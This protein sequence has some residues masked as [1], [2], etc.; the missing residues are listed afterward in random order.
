MLQGGVMLPEPEGPKPD[1]S[2]SATFVP[3]SAGA[4]IEE[5]DD[6]C[7]SDEELCKTYVDD[8]HSIPLL[9]TVDSHEIELSTRL[10]APYLQM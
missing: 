9:H 2:H 1:S 6:D 4:D 10:V 8:L 5:Y 7:I 3:S